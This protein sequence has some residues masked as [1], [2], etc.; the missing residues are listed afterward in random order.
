MEEALVHCALDR[1]VGGP[2]VAVQHSFKLI[3]HFINF[4]YIF[5]YFKK[6][7][8]L[9]NLFSYRGHY[10]LLIILV[11]FLCVYSDSS[12]SFSDI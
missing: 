3:L 11:T 2:G 5:Q 6:S 4:D 7:S 8:T 10:M 12:L 1:S 9:S